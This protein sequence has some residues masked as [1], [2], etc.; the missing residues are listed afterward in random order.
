MC[1][2][3]VPIVGA[4]IGA[5]ATMYAANRAS[6]DAEEARKQQEQQMKLAREEASRPTEARAANQY[7]TAA[8][9]AN[10]KRVAG[11]QGMGN[12]ITGA[13]LFDSNK[14]SG[15]NGVGGIGTKKDLG[16]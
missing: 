13:G 2:A 5:G 12:T 15:A 8:V 7:T 6:S 4:L 16:A 9:Q 1:A 10:R 3:A 11:M 14:Q